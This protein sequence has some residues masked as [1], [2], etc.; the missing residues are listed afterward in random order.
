MWTMIECVYG[1][2]YRFS[3]LNKV[4]PFCDVKVVSTFAITSCFIFK[5]IAIFLIFWRIYLIYPKY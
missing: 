4:L 5:K 2:K 1:T 3:Q